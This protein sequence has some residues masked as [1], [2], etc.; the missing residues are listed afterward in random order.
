MEAKKYRN[1]IF[2]DKN[3]KVWDLVEMIGDA[4]DE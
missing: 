2:F 1:I 3:G 4:S